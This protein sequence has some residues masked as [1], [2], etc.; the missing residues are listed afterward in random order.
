MRIKHLPLVIFSLV[1][2]LLGSLAPGREQPTAAQSSL[3]GTAAGLAGSLMGLTTVHPLDWE[4]DIPGSHSQGEWVEFAHTLG[5]EPQSL[6]PVKVYSQDY[7]TL[8]GVGKYTLPSGQNRVSHDLFGDGRDGDLMVGSGQTVYVD[9]VRSAVGDNSSAGQHTLAVA[10]T[11]GFSVGD[12][13]FIIQVQGTGAGLYEFGTIGSIDARSFT[14]QDPLVNTYTAVG[15]NNKAQVLKV[16][17]YRDLTVQDG[18]VLTARAWDG[19]SGGV[20]VFKA[21]GS[22]TIEGSARIDMAGKG[23]RGAPTNNNV[24][25]SQGE[26]QYGSGGQSCSANGVGGGG[27]GSYGYGD[28]PGGGGGGHSTSGLPGGPGHGAGSPCIGA[29]GETAGTPDLSRIFIGG[30]GG[31]GGAK[32]NEGSWN[33]G[34][35]GGSGGGVVL[36]FARDITVNGFISVDGGNGSLGGGG[37]HGGGGAGGTILIKAGTAEIGT[38][39][40]SATKGSGANNGSDRYGGDGGDGRIRIEYC[41]ALSG[42]STPGASTQKLNCYLAEQ[43]ESA[44]YDRARL[45]LPESFTDGRTYKVQYG[46]HLNFTIGGAQQATLRVPAG[47]YSAAT[48]DA[49]LVDAGSGDFTFRLDI[50][51]NGTWDWTTTQDVSG[52][53][54]LSSPDLAAAF[55]EYWASQGSP[56]SGDLDVPVVVWASRSARVLLTNLVMLRIDSPTPTPTATPT[57]TPTPTPTVQC[58][59]VMPPPPSNFQVPNDYYYR[60]SRGYG[61]GHSNVVGHEVWRSSLQDHPSDE[62]IVNTD[63]DRWWVFVVWNSFG[64]PYQALLLAPA[65]T[66]NGFDRG[67]VGGNS[68]FKMLHIKAYVEQCPG[69]LGPDITVTPASVSVTLP[70]GQSTTVPLKVGNA[71][72]AILTF[73]IAEEST[74]AAVSALARSLAFPPDNVDPALL[75]AL[76]TAPTGQTTFFV[77][78]QEQTDLTPAYAIKDWKARGEF[79][80]RTLR[81]TAQ[82]AQKDLLADL[83]RQQLTGAI[84]EYQPFFILNAIAVTGGRSAVDVLAARPDVAYLAPEPV[85]YIP[86]PLD[87]R[88]ASAA[89]AGVEWN[90]AQIRADRVW[91]DLGVTGTGVVVANIDTGVDHTHPTLVN[92][93][94]G[95]ASG[96]HDFNWFDPTGRYPDAPGDNHGHGTHVMGTMV[97]DDGAGNRIGVA[98]GAQWIAAKGC[99]GRGCTGED[100][101]K[102]AQWMLAPCP[103]GVQPGDAA[104]DPSKRPQVINN[105]W[106]GLGGDDWFE[107]IVSAWRASGIFPAFAAGNAGPGDG[108]VGSPG[109]YAFSFASG[110]TD[111]ADTVCWFSGRGP[112]RLT[113]KTKPNLTAPGCKGIR[114]ALPGGKYGTKNGTSMASPHTAGVVALLL[115]ANPNLTVEQIEEL[116]TRS[117]VDRGPA[118]PD[119]TYGYGRLDAYAAVAG[120]GDPIPWLS[121]NPTSGSV[122]PGDQQPVTLSIDTTGLLTGTHQANLVI[123]SNDP[124]QPTLTVPV[125]LTVT[126]GAPVIAHVR[127]SNLRDVS[128]SV[129]WITSV[130]ATGKVYYGTNPASLSNVAHDDRGAGT[131]DDIHHVTIGGLNPNTPYYF[132]V[133]SGG[134]ADDNEGEY[135]QFTTGAPLGVPS[136]DSVYG[137]VFKSDGTTPAADVLV[138]LRV[139]DNDS[140]GS[141]GQSGLLSGLTDSNGYWIDA[142]AGGAVN[143]AAARTEEDG[144]SYFIYSANG[145]AL[146]IEIHG[147]ADCD[148]L[149]QV[150]TGDDSPA[151]DIFLDCLNTLNL[152]I[153]PG[154]SVFVWP[155]TPA[156]AYS[157]S[158]LLGAIQEA[159]GDVPEVSQWVP[160]LGNWSGYLRGRLFNDFE[161]AP[162][163][164]Y[165]LRSTQHSLLRLEAGVGIVQGE[166]I[167]LTTGWNFVA[168]PRTTGVQVAEAACQEITAQG[169][170]VK[171]ID[172][173]M[174]ELGNWSGHICGTPIGDFE[175]TPEE[176]YFV[177]SQ[178]DSTWRPSGSAVEQ[179][180]RGARERGNTATRDPLFPYSLIPLSTFSIIGEVE[181]RNV[182]VTNVTDRSFTVLWETDQP[183]P[184][185]VRFG[186]SPALDGTASDDRGA[187]TTAHIHHVTVAGLSPGTTYYFAAVSGGTTDDNGGQFYEVTTGPTLGIPA[188]ETAYGRVLLTDGTT[189]ATGVLMK[190][191][192]EDGDGEGSSG[193]S[194]PLSAVTDGQ[195]YWSINLGATRTLAGDAYFDASGDDWL[196]VRAW[197]PALG[198]TARKM[199]LRDLPAALPLELTIARRTYL[200]LM[201][202]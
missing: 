178:A 125:T 10:N 27:G 160:E 187:D 79:V 55:N 102:A 110:A 85:Y 163:E 141:L 18:G 132:Y 28:A 112:S 191:V 98:P 67:T 46:R 181:I 135:Y 185:Q 54:T 35:A 19:N 23:F 14:M 196:V 133:V 62:Y 86:E 177:K 104:C 15:S 90:V 1:L 190:L 43:I 80:Y 63:S 83:R 101:L 92:Q 108:T 50:G 2:L 150:D 9:N 78:L 66:P 11:S 59:V 4:A 74:T 13:V 184:G 182:Q 118:G 194:A 169:G 171:E 6:H 105:S 39:H 84:T 96:S 20:A 111:Q 199:P 148:G 174:P 51:A 73:T 197:H 162:G 167:A 166:I 60:T 42:S 140:Q 147:G 68:G 26:G 45:N 145:D 94:R 72:D 158:D 87:E 188:V 183:A 179:R 116:L 99:A 32:T 76:D 201:A 198:W 122:E 173:W 153:T 57:N 113:P 157:A 58:P 36:V 109:D 3:N 155:A 175:M 77:Y 200:P 176:G 48:L 64:D 193:Q 115:G 38:S 192:L 114:S 40:V 120:A 25:G 16:P 149:T 82:R 7:S 95:A 138:Y 144:G 172:R 152:D 75:A 136:S 44:P 154:W 31:N 202:R 70:Q 128:A 107:A 170:S 41:D 159:D 88:D 33:Y 151:P 61:S 93:Y 189:P 97:G 5:P 47:Q 71:G 100:L 126:S 81:E 34:G 56:I 52:S 124:D 130:P 121:V 165:F 195:G 142:R 123:S 164:P 37:G 103:I 17:H 143:L 89:P 161:V 137:R 49:L 146:R 12:E 29:G 139:L 129:S 65:G 186:S 134:A 53:T 91:D 156:E 119:K 117:A 131:V 127:V 21:S 8:W 69:A 106:G 30:G 24:A 168:L 22:V 180:S